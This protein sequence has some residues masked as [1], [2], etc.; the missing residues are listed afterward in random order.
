[1][2]STEDQLVGQYTPLVRR[3]ALQLAARLPQSVELDDLVQAGMMGLLDAVRRYREMPQAQFDTY[4]VARIRGGMLD[5][6]RAQDWLPRSVRSKSRQIEQAVSSLV[7]RLGRPPTETEIAQTLGL[8]LREYQ[9][10]LEEAQGV[11]VIHYEDLARQSQ[12]ADHA[13]DV[14]ATEGPASESYWHDNPLSRLVSK[15]LRQALVDAISALPERE[16][17]LLSLQ[18][19]QDL[20][21]RE[22]AAV[23]GLTEGRVSQIRTQAV[24]RIRASL[25]ARDWHE[26]LEDIELQ[27]I[28]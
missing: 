12:D 23:L 7:Q 13:L 14:A 24:A 27:S 20:N 1:M 18:F 28:L 26:R 17:L 3:L 10:L 19:E 16:A 15:G 21:Q 8:P 2:S 6:L 11:Q 5:E 9:A 22:I 4:A 25:A